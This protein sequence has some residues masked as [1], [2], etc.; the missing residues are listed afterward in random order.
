MLPLQYEYFTPHHFEMGHLHN[1]HHGLA[2][3]SH[4]HHELP[5]YHN[6]L[7]LGFFNDDVEPVNWLEVLAEADTK[8]AP[9]KPDRKR[10]YPWWR[11]R[12]N[13]T[14]RRIC[15]S[16]K[17]VRDERNR[18]R[19]EARRRAGLK[20]PATK[21][22]KNYNPFAKPSKKTDDESEMII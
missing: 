22:Y 16:M 14:N 2:M 20:K 6:H 3:P 7:D 8:Q 21:I 15:K 4:F 1:L 13:R 18:R 11:R 5:A 17:C 19:A 12:S 9:A 10:P